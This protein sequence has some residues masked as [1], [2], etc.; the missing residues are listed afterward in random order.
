MGGSRFLPMKIGPRHKQARTQGKGKGR[1]LPFCIPAGT[2]ALRRKRCRYIHESIYPL[3]SPCRSP[4]QSDPESPD[5]D[6]HMAIAQGSPG[7]ALR[8]WDRLCGSGPERDKNMLI[9]EEKPGGS[10]RTCTTASSSEC[11]S[12]YSI[13][14]E[15]HAYHIP[16]GYGGIVTAW[17]PTPTN[18]GKENPAPAPDGTRCYMNHKEVSTGQGGGRENIPG[19]MGC[20]GGKSSA[21]SPQRFL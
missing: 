21:Q 5:A 4:P 13:L 2:H 3:F 11:V 19:T 8:G 10:I 16:S 20:R 9:R 6:S 17:G 14:A 18:P 1:C 12:E 15:D 7:L